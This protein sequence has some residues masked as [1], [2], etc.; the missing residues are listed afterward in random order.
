MQI[1]NRVYS[2]GSNKKQIMVVVHSR[3]FDTIFLL[4]NY[5]ECRKK[6]IIKLIE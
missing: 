1:A 3:S 5:S 2:A 6:L 4:V